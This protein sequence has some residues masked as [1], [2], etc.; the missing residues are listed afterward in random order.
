MHSKEFLKIILIFRLIRVLPHS[1][2][3][4]KTDVCIIVKDLE[5]GLKV[6]HE[7]SVNH[8]K[9]LLSE[10]GVEVSSVISL[11]ELK[12]DYKTF[13]SKTALC[14]RHEIFL[15][16]DRI[17][18]FLP[19]FLGKSFYSRKKFP[20]P[21]SKFFSPFITELDKFSNTFLCRYDQS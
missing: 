10:K 4:D 16:D 14:H 18:R 8:F 12:V 6:D 13:E 2:I 21:I 5:K 7:S 15:A 20:M 3:V 19:K 9:D 17:M 11:R 1:P